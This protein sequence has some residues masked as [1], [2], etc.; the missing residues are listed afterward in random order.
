[1][2]SIVRAL[3]LRARLLLVGDPYQLPP[4]GFGLVFQVLAASPKIPRIE[5]VEVHRQARSSGIPQTAYEIRHGVVPPLPPFAGVCA[6]VSFIEAGDSEVVDHILNVLAEWKGCDDIQV[7]AMTKRGTCGIR[8][9][10]AVLHALASAS[11]SGRVG[12]WRRIIYLRTITRRLW[13]DP[14]LNRAHK[15]ERKRAC[16]AR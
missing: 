10:N 13:T 7:L 14:G 2:Y 16:C 12:Y 6:G 5:L 11:K 9:I 8:N 15:F 1:M 4:I 3:P